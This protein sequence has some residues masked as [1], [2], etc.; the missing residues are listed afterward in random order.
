MHL[1]GVLQDDSFAQVWQFVKAPHVVFG[2]NPS[3]AA[4]VF[5]KILAA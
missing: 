3:P 2:G 4:Q 1:S 5:M